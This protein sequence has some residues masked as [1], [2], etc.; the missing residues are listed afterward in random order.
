M[1]FF[2]ETPEMI[3]LTVNKNRYSLSGNDSCLIP[4]LH[5]PPL[6]PC[7]PPY[8]QEA[9]IERPVTAPPTLLGGGEA[10]ILRLEEAARPSGAPVAAVPRGWSGGRPSGETLERERQ[11][12]RKQTKHRPQVALRKRRC[13]QH[14]QKYCFAPRL[15]RPWLWL[16]KRA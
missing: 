7:Q 12:N 5:I 16:R 11:R 9:Q 14:V 1:L 4:N 15:D 3:L 10:V 13:Q 8:Q 2:L 6:H